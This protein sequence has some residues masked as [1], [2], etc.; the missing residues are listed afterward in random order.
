[1]AEVSREQRINE[2]FVTVADSLI[3]DFDLIDML[4]TLA[5]VCAD[6]LDVKAAGLVLADESGHLQL[7][8]STSEQADFVEVMQMNAGT[9]P[10]IDSFRTGQV[11]AVTDIAETGGQW[12]E[13]QAAA[14]LQGFRSVH[15]TPMR[16]RGQVLG[17]LNLFG[18]EVGELNAADAG[19]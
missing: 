16:L 9:G 1:M 8:A 19:G 3:A 17:A 11:V 15:A 7:L 6:V 4:H 10:C 2:A 14:L 5:G 18:G 12:P 13:F